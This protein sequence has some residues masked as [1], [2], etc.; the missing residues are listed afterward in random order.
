MNERQKSEPALDLYD[1][2]RDS[3]SAR[4][5]LDAIVDV[6][7]T[8]F[9][10]YSDEARSLAFLSPA[11]DFETLRQ[12]LKLASSATSFQKFCA[13]LDALQASRASQV[14]ALDEEQSCELVTAQIFNNFIVAILEKRRKI[15]ASFLRRYVGEI[16]PK[17][18]QELDF[19][20]YETAPT[21]H[22]FGTQVA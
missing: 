18:A 19:D 21:V 5:E 17:V 7:K 8:R 11:L 13:K 14:K 10:S 3:L 1:S 16:S 4:Y 6:L 20:A 15:G 22:I 12:I 2:E 9:P